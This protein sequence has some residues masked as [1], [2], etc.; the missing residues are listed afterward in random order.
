MH[1]GQSIDDRLSNPRFGWGEGDDIW[2]SPSIPGLGDVWS[3]LVQ[4]LPSVAQSTA[5][6]VAA[7]RGQPTYAASPYPSVIG[8]YGQ[9]QTPYAGSYPVQSS[10]AVSPYQYQQPVA[11]TAPQS[12]IIPGIDNTMLMLVGG[13]AAL[14]LVLAMM[15]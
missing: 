9:A 15:K 12:Q 4:A 1:M 14:L 10:Y 6:I 2:S 3:D 8:S 11:Y 13:G 5:Q 7:T